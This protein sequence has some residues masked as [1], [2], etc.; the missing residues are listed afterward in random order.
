MLERWIVRRRRPVGDSYPLVGGRCDVIDV[1][2]D[3]IAVWS[4]DEPPAHDA[5]ARSFCDVIIGWADGRS[6]QTIFIQG[7]RATAARLNIDSVWRAE[8]CLGEF[9]LNIPW[10]VILMLG[11]KYRKFIS[12]STLYCV[13]FLYVVLI[14]AGWAF[15]VLEK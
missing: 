8:K 6:G 14:A 1:D 3:L 4:S 15:Q 2:L 12:P 5:G 10:I 9:T 11:I 7:D 13:R